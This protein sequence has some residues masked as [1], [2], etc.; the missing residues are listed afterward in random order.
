[1]I[2]IALSEALLKEGAAGMPTR[3]VR[4]GADR[5]EITSTK[6]ERKSD[7]KR[8]TKATVKEEGRIMGLGTK[9]EIE[10]SGH[11]GNVVTHLFPSVLLN[12]PFG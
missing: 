12:S 2:A 10:S 3:A 4:S 7:K 1:M 11:Y 9:G 5:W 8:L 6:D